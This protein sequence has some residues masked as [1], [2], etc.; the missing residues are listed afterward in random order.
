MKLSRL[1]TLTE[2]L[3]PTIRFNEGMNVV[4]AQVKDYHQKSQDAHNLGKTFLTTVIDFCLLSGMKAEHPFAKHSDRFSTF[5]F[6]L[7]ILTNN[8][9]YL[10]IRRSVTGAKNIAVNISEESDDMR[11]VPLNDWTHSGLGVEKAKKIID[12]EVGLSAIQPYDYRKGLGYFL[13]RQNDYDDVFRISK[14]G[15]GKDLDWKPFMA[16]LLGFDSE[17]IR[18]KYEIDDEIEGVER[19]IVAVES[20]AGASTDQLDEVQG[21][22]ALLEQRVEQRRQEVDEFR[23]YDADLGVTKELVE[24][25]EKNIGR[26]NELRYTAMSQI[27]EVR[28]ALNTD[29]PFDLDQIR[30]LFE[31]TKGYFPDLME[32]DY[33]RLVEFNKGLSSSRKDR[34]QQ[35]LTRLEQKCVQYNFELNELDGE[36]SKATEQLRRAETVVKYKELGRRLIDEEEQL[37]GLRSVVQRLDSTFELREKLRNLKIKRLNAIGDIEKMVSNPPSHYQ[38][39]RRM[40]GDFA[41]EVLNVYAILS[42]RPN[43]EGNLEFECTIARDSLGVGTTS[44]GDGFSYQKMLCVCFDLALICSF[45]KESFYR[46]VYHDGVFETLDDRRKIKML[47][48]IRNLIE[49]YKIQYVLTVID[50]DLPRSE[51]DQKLFFSSNEVI[52]ELH[53][54]GD[55]GRL[56]PGPVF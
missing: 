9:K 23:F 38:L 41:R 34:L 43:G 51:D 40:F 13:R 3:F 5:T 17:L 19:D 27:E 20:Q 25:I 26:L 7:E 29:L 12:G 54:Q 30:Q 6:F 56:F 28:K 2:E 10:T 50:S 11:S 32:K 4:F 22:I 36:R 53:D 44:E 24:G 45:A 18:T 47:D 21:K 49:S 14:F 42:V 31:E 16:L 46:F 39:V 1:Y 55:S 35:H 48:E 15:R 52:R 37:I 33:Q 8:G